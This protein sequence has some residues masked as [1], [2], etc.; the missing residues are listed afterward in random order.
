MVSGKTHDVGAEYGKQ[1]E[2]PTPEANRHESEEKL[3]VGA[4][5]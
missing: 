5:W 2:R 1:A 4:R 3:G